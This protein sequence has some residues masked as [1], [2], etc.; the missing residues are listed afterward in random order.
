MPS[1]RHLCIFSNLGL[2][3]AATAATQTSVTDST[4]SALLVMGAFG[5]GNTSPTQILD[6]EINSASQAQRG[7]FYRM[8]GGSLDSMFSGYGAGLCLPYGPTSA[9]SRYSAGHLFINDGGTLKV[10]WRNVTIADGTVTGTVGIVRT[11]LNTTT[12]SDGTLKV[13]S[14]IVKLF[15]DGGCELND[16]SEGC[17]VTRLSAGEYLIEGCMGL[18]ADAEWGGIDG[19]FDIPKDRNGQPLIWLDYEVNADG[20]VLVKTYH[21]TYPDSPPFARHDIAGL[22]NGEP[23]DIPVDQFVSVRVEMPQDSNWNQRQKAN[24][25]EMETE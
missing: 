12:A 5:L 3:N 24:H 20:S 17:T 18:N 14:P 1:N 25:A 11:T 22:V 15:S 21:R 19:G 13:A 16:E 6:S 23:V 4:P 7:R 2:G 8:G 9:G 10:L